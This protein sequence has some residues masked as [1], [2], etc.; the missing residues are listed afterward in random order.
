MSTI[1]NLR[2]YIAGLDITPVDFLLPLHEVVVNSIQSIE[3]SDNNK[4]GLIT[5]NTLRDSQIIIESE[6]EGKPYSPIIGFEIIDNGIGFIS[7]RFVA[8]NELGIIFDSF[9]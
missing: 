7:K 6:E 1:V 5:I 2:S 4:S 8:F 3:D 9:R